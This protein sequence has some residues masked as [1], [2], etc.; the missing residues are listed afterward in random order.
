M[1]PAPGRSIGD[2]LTWV[3]E[4]ISKNDPLLIGTEAIF[5]TVAQVNEWTR[6]N[7]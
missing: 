6:M 4:R 5:N 2:W 3:E 7:V 1:Q